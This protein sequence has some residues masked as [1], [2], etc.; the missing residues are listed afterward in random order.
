MTRR[1]LVLFAALAAT[2]F[3]APLELT[4]GT[5]LEL[6][7]AATGAKLLATADAYFQRLSPFDRAAKMRMAEPP[8]P[9][10]FARNAAESVREFTD[11]D[12]AQVEAAWAEMRPLLEPLGL[13]FPQR[14]TLVKTNGKDDINE[15][16]CRGPVIVLPEKYFASADPRRLS[17]VLLHELFHVFSTHH[18]ELRDRLYALLDYLPCPEIALPPAEDARRFTNPDAM[19]YNYYTVLS[20]EGR[21]LAVTPVLLARGDHYDPAVRGSIFGQVSLLLVELDVRDGKA[22][23][24]LDSQGRITA[25]E[26]G[27]VPAF[28]QRMQRNTGYILHPEEVLADNFVHAAR[29]T[30]GLSAPELPVKLLEVMQSA[31][32]R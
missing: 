15:A 22:S 24:V 1:A 14:V 21:D 31:T 13:D 7:D 17:T 27:E 8:S 2:G 16:Y 9:G 23:P 4:P 30:A 28:M 6:A 12:R 32:A 5:Q 20:H 19:H 29:K 26:A 10:E 11:T 3:A 25:R 18:P